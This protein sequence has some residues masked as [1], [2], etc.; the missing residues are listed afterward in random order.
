[1]PHCSNMQAPVQENI[2]FTVYKWHRSY[3]IF[4]TLLLDSCMANL[5]PAV[6]IPL[7][8]RLWDF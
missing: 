1:M 2:G 3:N 7:L 5:T 8:K 4:W 6:W